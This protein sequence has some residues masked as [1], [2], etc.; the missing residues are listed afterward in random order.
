MSRWV[1][2]TAYCAMAAWAL[3]GTVVIAQDNGAPAPNVPAAG[4][5]RAQE[6]LPEAPPEK[7]LKTPPPIEK[8]PQDKGDAADAPAPPPAAPAEPKKEVQPR[9]PNT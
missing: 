3:A 4:Q 8:T 7:M 6:K 1:T 5:P 2:C 9:V